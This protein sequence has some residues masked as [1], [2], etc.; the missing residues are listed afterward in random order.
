MS[1]E[2]VILGF[3]VVVEILVGIYGV[4]KPN[5]SY[6]PLNGLLRRRHPLIG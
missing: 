2:E 1:V 4:T 6:S 5:H 3:V